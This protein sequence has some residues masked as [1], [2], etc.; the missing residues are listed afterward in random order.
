MIVS[1]DIGTSNSSI[2]MMGADGNIVSL[3][4]STGA[5]I[6][7]DK[8]SLPSAVFVEDSGN[9][10]LGQAAM[11]NRMLKPQNLRAE[12]KRNLGEKYPIASAG[13]SA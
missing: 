1:I 2:C 10:V 5:S 7:G 4:V 3:D 13:I 9:L 11:N 8:H 12:F 6:Y